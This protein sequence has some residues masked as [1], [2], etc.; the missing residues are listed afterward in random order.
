MPP[1]LR[2]CALAAAAMSSCVA[3]EGSAERAPT[4]R[5]VLATRHALEAMPD[6]ERFALAEATRTAL[7]ESRLEAGARPAAGAMS[8]PLERTREL[9]ALHALLDESRQRSGLD[10]LTAG[11]YVLADGLRAETCR[12]PFLAGAGRPDDATL[13]PALRWSD[14]R[15]RP[16]LEA[17]LAPWLGSCIE[18]PSATPVEVVVVRGAP[19]VA[20]FWPEAHQL[21]LHP[22]AIDLLEHTPQAP[23]APRERFVTVTK[24]LHT[25]VIAC[26]DELRDACAECRADRRSAQCDEVLGEDRFAMPFWQPSCGAV[27]AA[28]ANHTWLESALCAAHLSHE[29]GACLDCVD[30]AFS[31]TCIVRHQDADNALVEAASAFRYASS[32]GC[33]AAL[34]RCAADPDDAC[35]A[36][37]TPEPPEGA[38]GECVES[39]VS[40][41]TSCLEA[42]SGGP[43]ACEPYFPWSTI[44]QDCVDLGYPRFTDPSR[45]DMFCAWRSEA[46]AS[47]LNAFEPCVRSEVTVT[48]FDT[49]VLGY[50]AFADGTTGCIAQLQACEADGGIA[51]VL[52]AD[53]PPWLEPDDGASRSQDDDDGICG[54]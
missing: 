33:V 53:T 49:L 1:V 42:R 19:F 40:T 31:A 13:A 51:P 47:C 7:A 4:L 15:P 34:E 5:Q 44:E 39:L 52:D 50:S 24:P 2:L 3:C 35:R 6:A 20:A 26:V 29:R 16:A 32:P 43:S 14:A 18:A 17:A 25:S 46:R 54:G 36:P 21:L 45:L 38:F 8:N 30:P 11:R 37:V 23:G 22:L 12:A 41:C 27:V 48:S 28:A 10:V 9:M